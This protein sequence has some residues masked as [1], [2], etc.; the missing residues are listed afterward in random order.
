MKITSGTSP[1]LKG[2]CKVIIFGDYCLN[3]LI[4]AFWFDDNT[5]INK[6]F[7]MQDGKEV[8]RPYTEYLHFSNCY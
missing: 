2:I 7:I 8:I 4:N 3:E 5:P 1:D 6:G